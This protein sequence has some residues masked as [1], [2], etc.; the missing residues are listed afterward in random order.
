MKRG[1]RYTLIIAVILLAAVLL[2]V[3]VFQRSGTGTVMTSSTLV[4]VIDISELSTAEF[5]YNG[6]AE[7][8]WDENRTNLRCRI[9]Y[10]ATVKA[11]IDMKDVDFLIDPESRTITAIL[12]EIRVNVSVVDEKTMQLMPSDANIEID[13]MLGVSREDVEKE[14]R[15][16][17]ELMSAAR[18]NLEST[19][20][21]L[22]RPIAD[23]EG[24]SIRFQ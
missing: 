1:L 14:A 20:E 10:S 4:K 11:G 21:A 9:C 8:Y 22:L 23:R 7:V 12:P 19:I 6:I 24:Y 13:V 15:E 16:S 3:L 5:R 17:E 2:R 18:K